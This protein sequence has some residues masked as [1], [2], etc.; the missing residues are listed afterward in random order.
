[1]DIETL[2]KA[3]GGTYGVKIYDG[4]GSN[5][6]YDPSGKTAYVTLLVNPIDRF[7]RD[8][9]KDYFRHKLPSHIRDC[10]FGDALINYGNDIETICDVVV[11]TVIN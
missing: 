8:F 4:Y 10:S 9:C 5:I 1:M 11:P 2:P 6:K 3:S 7:L